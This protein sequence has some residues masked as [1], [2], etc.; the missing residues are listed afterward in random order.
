MDLRERFVKVFLI[1]LQKFQLYK[2]DHPES[3]RYFEKLY[4]LINKILSMDGEL[5]FLLTGENVYINDKRTHLPTNKVNLIKK[6]FQERPFSGFQIEQ[7]CQKD[8]I[9]LLFKVMIDSKKKSAK[10][11]N[12]TKESYEINNS[13]YIYHMGAKNFAIGTDNLGSESRINFTQNGSPKIVKEGEKRIISKEKEIGSPKNITETVKKEKIQE[14]ADQN[15]VAQLDQ[16]D[17]NKIKENEIGIREIEEKYNLVPWEELNYL[18]KSKRIAKLKAL[19]I[20]LI[21]LDF[22]EMFENI[23]YEMIDEYFR[24]L[25]EFIRNNIV[26]RRTKVRIS[27]IKNFL[28]LIDYLKCELITNILPIYNFLVDFANQNSQF[29]SVEFKNNLEDVTFIIFEK[30][31]KNDNYE[32]IKNIFRKIKTHQKFRENLSKSRLY[33]CIEKMLESLK[34]TSTKAEKEIIRE[35]VLMMGE[36]SAKP[37]LQMLM[38]EEDRNMRRKLIS[39]IVELGADVIPYLK[40]LLI[41]DRWFVVRNGLSILADLEVEINYKQLQPII[42]HKDFRVRKELIRY[43][44]KVQTLD[45]AEILK[46]V[47][48]KENEPE[49][50]QLAINNIS[51]FVNMEIMRELWNYFKDI[52][53]DGDYFSLA[54]LF[55]DEFINYTKNENPKF[56]SKLYSILE[57]STSFSLLSTDQ[58]TRLKLYLIERL[59]KNAPDIYDAFYKKMNT[60]NNKEVIKVLKKI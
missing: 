15:I 19:P 60:S 34:K 9:S 56:L 35:S 21:E 49:L 27:I 13:N 23:A 51:E 57:F 3:Q 5:I 26:D 54:K 8:E 53:A 58:I 46:E 25:E 18:E 59:K 31:H 12:K 29:I 36:I 50:Q 38:E 43:L 22:L 32:N 39:M 17:L 33:D 47:I 48:F 2:Y 28:K 40:R 4:S 24:N 14:S 52:A 30:L 37:L 42:N 44:H 41:D 45:A 16:E 1:A 7:G 55:I 20:E 10:W 6:F 11:V